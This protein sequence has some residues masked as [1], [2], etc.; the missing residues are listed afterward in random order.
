MLLFDDYRIYYKYTLCTIKMSHI[1]L[2]VIIDDFMHLPDQCEIMLLLF[3]SLYERILKRVN[4][5]PSQLDGHFLY[6]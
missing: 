3:T 1:S 6:Y 4:L 2:C 5:K